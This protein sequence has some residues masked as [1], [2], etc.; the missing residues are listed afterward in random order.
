MQFGLLH[1]CS[2]KLKV[3][4]LI[5]MFSRSFLSLNLTSFYD[6]LIQRK[7]S[8]NCHFKEEKWIEF[9]S[10][11]RD[12]SILKVDVLLSPRD[13]SI[14]EGF[15]IKAGRWKRLFW[16]KMGFGPSIWPPGHSQPACE[17][18]QLW[19]PCGLLLCCLVTWACRPSFPAGFSGTKP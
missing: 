6:L 8:Q 16:G 2:W 9:T 14:M 15:G 1:I 12:I 19:L 7:Q 5:P 13:Y 3:R 17:S 11:P 4:P 10:G 18:G